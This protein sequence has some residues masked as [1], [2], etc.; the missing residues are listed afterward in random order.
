MFYCK[1]KRE[2]PFHHFP[3]AGGPEKVCYLPTLS[4]KFPSYERNYAFLVTSLHNQAYFWTPTIQ[5]W[6]WRQ[7]VPPKFQYQ[8]TELYGFTVQ[9]T[10]NLNNNYCDTS[11]YLSSVLSNTLYVK[12]K[13][14]IFWDITPCSLL[15]RFAACFYAGFLL[16]FF[17]LPWRWR[18]YVPPKGRLAFNGLHGLVSQNIVLFLTTAVRTSNPTYVEYKL[19]M[20]CASV[21]VATKEHFLDAYNP[22]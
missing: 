13:S 22:T 21:V 1:K 6:R 4:F 12:C 2:S 16:S 10:P 18:R 11:K 5:S 9:K 20:L 3:S 8:P 19:Q 7:Y 17:F 14:T 15:S